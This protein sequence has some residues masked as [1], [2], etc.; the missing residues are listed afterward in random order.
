MGRKLG[1]WKAKEYVMLE[2]LIYQGI[3][4]GR[5]R[6]WGAFTPENELTAGAFFFESN[7]KAVFHFS[8]S[9]EEA[10]E[11]GALP[12]LIDTFIRENAGRNIVFDFEGSVI[13]GL[14]RFYRSFGSKECVYLQ[15]RIN[16]LP[17]YLHWLK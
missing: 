11:S 6:V 10:K 4:K 12:L 13:P 7:G 1:K 2:H 16:R 9:D 14:A 3:H 5:A 8:A 15:V 17:W